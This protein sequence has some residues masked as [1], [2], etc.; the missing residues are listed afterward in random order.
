MTVSHP[1]PARAAGHIVDEQARGQI[2]TFLAELQNGTRNYRTVA[3]LGAQVAQEYRGRAIL[4]L[5]QNAHDVLAFAGDD[6]SRRISFVL[7]SGDEPELLVANSGRPFRVL[8]FRGICQLAQSPKDPNESV[9]NKG[10][11]FQSVLELSRR[12]EVWSTAPAGGEPAFTFGF[13]P[14]VRGPIGRVAQALLDG[15]PPI[16]PA[17]GAAA[18]VDW[19]ETQVE[20]Y[21]E[22]LSS[23]GVD[24]AKEVEDYL[25]PYVV[26]RFLSGPPPEVEALL[27]DGHVTVVRLPLDGGKTGS[28][29]DAVESV[30]RQ[31]EALDE[32]AMVFL[33]HLSV[34]RRDI[35]GDRVEFER[36]LDSELSFSAPG[37]WQ[38][39]RVGRKVPDADAGE[40][41]ERSFHLWRRVAGGD[42]DSEGAERIAAAVRHLPNRWPDLRQVEIA[43]AVEETAEP[44][45]GVF[46]I[47][48]PTK[49]ETGVAALVNAPFYG[50]L[51][52]RQINFDDGYNALLLK[53]VADLVL[54]A[55]LD[56]V[57]GPPDGWR[58][59]AVIDL[60]G[61]GALDDPLR[62]RAE[63]R[64]RP[65]AGLPLI[66]CDDGWR[67]PG[68]ARTMPIV[69]D[70]DPIGRGEWRRRAGFAVASSALDQR[71]EAVETLLRSL[72]GSPEPRDEEWARTL[73]RLAEHVRSAQ[74]DAN[75][76]DFL[77]SVLS[78]LPR[79]LLGEPGQPEADPLA[80]ARFLP[81]EDGRLLS[82]S[83]DVRIFFRPRR[84]A[85][86]AADFVGSV[87]KSL[88]ERIAFLHHSVKTHEGAQRRSTEVQK[89]L[90]GRFV[91]SFRREDLLR[92]VVIPSL[93]R[94]PV[95]HGT[96]EADACAETLAWTLEV[97]GEEAR[98]GVVP[99]LSHLPVA[100]GGGW[101]AM[102][103]ATFG[104]GWAGRSGDH[105]Q[106]LA[107]DLPGEDGEELLRTAL[108]APDDARWEA[109]DVGQ[110]R[111]DVLARAE[112][113][114]SAGVVEGLR[115]VD[116]KAIRFWMD[117]GGAEPP[118][119]GPEIVP[120]AAWED[121]R[122]ASG[123]IKP[124]HRL[125]HEYELRGVKAL[126]LLH[127]E[128]LGDAARA[129]LSRLVLASFRYW[130]DGWE[131]VHVA[132]VRGEHW[133]GD[134]K[135][136][137][138][139]WLSTLPWLD[140]GS[141]AL[142]LRQRWFVPESL[143]R[144]QA[145]RFRHLS[146]LSMAL[147]HRLA[148]DEAL[149]GTLRKLGLNVYPTEEIATG[150]ALLEA[151]ADVVKDEGP[152]LGGRFDVI[153]GQIRHAWRHLDP[154][155][156]L[157]T[158]FLVRTKPRKL[159]LRTAEELS[160]VY[161]PDD[162]ARTRSL[163]EHQQPIV[164]MRPEE[165]RGG[166]GDRLQEHGARRA[167]GL[168]E[169]CLIDGHPVDRVADGAQTLDAAG[170]KWLPV[171]LLSVA[172]HGGGNP[173]GPATKAWRE[174]AGGLRRALV[175]RCDSIRVELLDGERN[176]AG[177]EPRAHWLASPGV[178]LVDRQTVQGGRWEEMAAAC[179]SILDRRDLLKDLRL[180]LGSLDGRGPLHG[181][182]P[183]K[184]AA[185][186]DRA[187]IDAEA[188]ADIRLRWDGETGVL[189]ERLRPLAKLLG[190]ATDDLEAGEDE[191]DDVGG[192]GR[193]G[194]D[195]AGDDLDTAKLDAA[196]RATD[197]DATA[198]PDTS[199]DATAA[200]DTAKLDAE[201]LTEWLAGGL[202]ELDH[203][204]EPVARA[205]ELLDAARECHDDFEMGMRAWKLLGEIA[206]L[207][208][209]N[210]ALRELGGEY[211]EVENA[212][213]GE[214]VVR[215]LEEAGWLLRAFARHVATA[216]SAVSEDDRAE[217]Y[218]KIEGVR[219]RLRQE[220]ATNG[221][222]EDG[223]ANW[224]RRWWQVPFRAVLDAL[225]ARYESI[226]AARSYLGAFDGVGTIAE[227]QTAL[228]GRRILEMGVEVERDPRVVARDNEDQLD[229]VL[230]S[231]RELYRAWL[232]RRGHGRDG[233]G[234]DADSGKGA[235][236][237]DDA[238]AESAPEAPPQPDLNAEA[239]P[240][241]PPRP[242]LGAAIYL[243]RWSEG[244]LLRRVVCGI[245]DEE[246]RVGCTGCDTVEKART[247]LG[248]SKEDLMRAG[249]AI[250]GTEGKKRRAENTF[251][252]AGEPFEIGGTQTYGDLFKRLVGLSEP[253]GGHP[254][255]SL[256][257]T[258]SS[259]PA[260][261]GGSGGEGTRV[262]G[263]TGHHHANPHRPE[264]IGIVGEMHALRFLRSKFG[265]E[266]VS[267]QAWVS[268]FRT[269]VLP[270]LSGE[271]DRTS[272]SLGYDFRFAHDGKTW[273]VE[274]KAT[275]EHGTSFD[276][277]SG[278]IAAA[279]GVA[280][281]EDE[282]WRILRVRRVFCKKPEFD[283][284]PNPFGPGGERLQIRRGGVTVEYARG[285]AKPQ[286]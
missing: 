221:G 217:L 128:G 281:T 174:A 204:E 134:F 66:L 8:D 147:A 82:E 248:I 73:E 136:P 86:D 107:D 255:G 85:D 98:K 212:Q 3:S 91:R 279:K 152:M 182:S 120:K 168:E 17:F 278:Q 208:E 71:R 9:G 22:R 240:E 106:A 60:V 244:E 227:L 205:R 135:S 176:V 195:L 242:D 284:L 181:P 214:Q 187:E 55:T 184:I 39:L 108:L 249:K 29:E 151:L 209:W 169:R 18:V 90:D 150:P 119:P 102:D 197:K 15:E 256:P 137:L 259:R 275:T 246:F 254:P 34:L 207:P 241:A 180:V 74:E 239:V 45:A 87:P 130:E 88:K 124:H 272:D 21:R 250:R 79:E 50:S 2:R 76:N 77:A 162:V 172:A 52:R 23:D 263:K 89:F 27:A 5:L 257:S 97:I 51:D 41:T 95:A 142:P 104:P 67:A 159:I 143:L 68:D 64:G 160:D 145:G 75:W 179:Q 92:E 59:R 266:H 154:E 20:E 238:G 170:L 198:A 48:L 163:R 109:G 270:L 99:L 111:G 183:G 16:D 38:R 230:R 7:K 173:T 31:L 274:V 140:D 211:R 258:P 216:D 161:L 78:M 139:H 192:D 149:L 100:C 164:A 224:S 43:V 245:E 215:H 4:E 220:A 35:D 253:D 285:P 186:L 14:D 262:G 200:P 167:S 237:R 113:F 105:L 53:F 232:L 12:P 148:E 223:G 112:L 56:L 268:E 201:G 283:W 218:L 265:T 277:S 271:E 83:D 96:P 252:I 171:V 46:V 118:G 123:R 194:D 191:N 63:D 228:V 49:V 213:A 57:E 133:S 122:K 138:R 234:G 116:C 26:P 206:T 225:R 190:L 129:A 11:G 210:A 30:R 261:T 81:T 62:R 32:A 33:G 72:D 203:V 165:A 153:L 273:C 13:N 131:R 144:G 264:L 231:V 229:S 24:P 54:D 166:V 47:F 226:E 65:L 25:S 103:E 121:W 196:A 126:P 93:P 188:L 286:E 267:D 84:G 280:A 36:T 58:G 141:H 1:P 10:L 251:E 193:D 199:K 243:R 236:P 222:G 235:P 185:A 219:K 269:K 189:L 127:R 260:R 247:R 177:S 115:I 282:H 233:G 125:H 44:R 69:Q 94:L 146:P 276:L 157:P 158:R 202:R 114:E 110:V 42:G 101:F 70:D 155:R 178:L 175:R 28:P 19:S 61:S 132:K 117:G 6:D 80:N 40:A 156:D 37:S